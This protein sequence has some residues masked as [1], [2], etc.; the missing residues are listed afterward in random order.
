MRT[1]SMPTRPICRSRER[2]HPSVSRVV[3]T[4]LVFGC[5]I[6]VLVALDKRD[7]ISKN[8]QTASEEGGKDG[9]T[10][11]HV[12]PRN[13]GLNHEAAKAEH[14]GREQAHWRRQTGIGVVATGLS[15]LA[16]IAAFWGYVTLAKTLDETRKQA[17]ATQGQLDVIVAAQ[18]AMVF[19]SKINMYGI[20][21]PNSND[22][23]WT[24]GID[25]ENSGSTPTKYLTVNLR[26]WVEPHS[27]SDWP[28]A[29]LSIPQGAQTNVLGP[30][31]TGE[32]GRCRWL[33]S[34]LAT[35]QASESALYVAAR[36]DYQDVF[37][38]KAWHITEVCFE[39]TP[40]IG[41]PTHLP[42]DI[43]IGSA[44]C[45]ALNCADTECKDQHKTDD[46]THRGTSRTP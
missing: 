38:G 4:A 40:I 19:E 25:W 10:N 7:N 22:P 15:G 30:H 27:I 6:A 17:N 42:S 12:P 33:A 45:P 8:Y 1:G 44:T 14:R 31:A 29:F 13:A 21:P 26:C 2:G 43:K 28:E 46:D 11:Q 37:N 39:A 24:F 20:L 34:S 5:F 36:A 41:D 23:V 3:G 32:I 18:R 9:D 35:I 16:L